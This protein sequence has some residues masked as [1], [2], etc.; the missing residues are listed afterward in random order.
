M[1]KLSKSDTRFFPGFSETN[2]IRVVSV[3]T[4]TPDN[5]TESN[6][7]KIDRMLSSG[8]LLD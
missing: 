7:C 2:K 8:G 6:E 3:N 4:L 5:A 1:N